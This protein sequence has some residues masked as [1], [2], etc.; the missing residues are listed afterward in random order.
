MVVMVMASLI[1][2][3][4]RS[5]SN[6]F[7]QIAPRTFLVWRFFRAGVTVSDGSDETNPWRRNPPIK[8]EEADR[9]AQ[10][11]TVRYVTRREE[12]AARVEFAGRRLESVNIA[13]LSHHWIEVDRGDVYPGRSVTRMDDAANSR[14]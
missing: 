12:S 9:I 8:D 2:G 13:G 10:L 14:T 3:I 1:S 6:L 4:N 5:V 11:P 7:E